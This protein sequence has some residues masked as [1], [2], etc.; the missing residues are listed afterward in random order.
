MQKQQIS[1]KFGVEGLQAPCP[2]CCSLFTAPPSLSLDVNSLGGTPS[3]EG[4]RWRL[5]PGFCCLV[6]SDKEDALPDLPQNLVLGFLCFP[7]MQEEGQTLAVI[8]ILATAVLISA[9]ESGRLHV[10][11]H[12]AT[13]RVEL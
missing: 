11:V 1:V 4:P 6:L 10:Q 5:G 12:R 13:G 7:R 2:L 8:A 3:S 9:H